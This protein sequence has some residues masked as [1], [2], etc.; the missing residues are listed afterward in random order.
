MNPTDLETVPEFRERARRWLKDNLAPTTKTYT[1][2]DDDAVWDRARALQRLLHEGGFAGLCFPK[3]YGGQGL[4]PAHQRA[5]TEESL[6]YEMPLVLNVPTLA[7]CAATILDLGTEEQKRAHLPAVLRGEEILSQFLS[8]PRGG[9]DLAGLT[10]RADA[11]GT[12]WILNGAKI[13]SSGAYGADYGLC[14]ARTNWDVPK[15]AGLTL[16]L[17][18]CRAAGVTIRRIRQVTGSTEFCQEFFDDVRLPADSVL[19]AVDEGWAATR[20]LLNHERAAVGGTSPYT[21]GARPHLGGDVSTLVDLARAVGALGDARVR[22]DIGAARARS[23][24]RDQLIAH[25]SHAVTSGAMPAAAGSL[26]R[27]F[28][29]EN[30]GLQADMAVKIAGAAAA[31]EGPHDPD[32]RIGLDYLFRAAWSLAGGSTE[33]SRNI[34]SERLLNMPREFA[35]DHGVPFNRVERGG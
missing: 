20:R 25:V 35:A 1:G 17:V 23:L 14:L 26:V 29:A 28:S 16:F 30:A 24:V 6:G 34:I 13:W 19:G 22:E 12:D 5:F 3:A 10:T 32:H 21:S 2:A 33:M 15:H 7:I 27:V 8:E 9:S 11:D 31:T 18:P 4:T